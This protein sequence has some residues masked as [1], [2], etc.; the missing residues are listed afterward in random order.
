[1]QQ[2]LLD[3]DGPIV[4]SE[5]LVFDICRMVEP[6][7]SWEEMLLL[8]Y[9]NVHV[10][11]G[12]KRRLQ[13]DFCT[14]TYREGVLNIAPVPGADKLLHD[15]AN[16]GQKIIF[17]TSSLTESVER[18]L[19]HYHLPYDE[20][21]GADKGKRKTEKMEIVMARHGLRSDKAVYV[22]DTLGDVLEAHQVGLESIAVT[23]GMHREQEFTL[24]S[25]RQMA[26][27][28]DELH[29]HLIGKY[30]PSIVAAPQQ[31]RQPLLAHMQYLRR[32]S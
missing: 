17:I 7:I 31:D 14:D 16:H 22:T 20:V 11:E 18:Y 21:W 26:H 5:Q 15:L 9:G 28:M 2:P 8:F 10:E 4:S 6:D 12:A 13:G 25:P 32:S 23:W 1:M 24:G 19:K 27:T 3:F 29:H 30:H